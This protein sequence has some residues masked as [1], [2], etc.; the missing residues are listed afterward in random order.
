VAFQNLFHDT[1]QT[2]AMYGQQ[3]NINVYCNLHKRDEQ[4]RARLLVYKRHVYSTVLHRL[5]H[6]YVSSVFKMNVVL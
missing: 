6:Q 1:N 4:N 5:C 3:L 2:L